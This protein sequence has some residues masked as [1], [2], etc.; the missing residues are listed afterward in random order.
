MFSFV[1]VEH[2]QRRA[3]GK[4]AGDLPVH[5]EVSGSFLWCR[6]GAVDM[7]AETWSGANSP[8]G[9]WAFGLDWRGPRWGAAKMHLNCPDSRCQGPDCGWWQR[10]YRGEGVSQR[11]PE[12]SQPTNHA[13]RDEERIV[14]YWGFIARCCV[15]GSALNRNWSSGIGG[16][17]SG[18]KEN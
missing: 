15:W 7:L 9:D 1:V 13:S 10:D 3:I 16:E 2:T 12:P 18:R 11:I 6:R 4:V 5:E 17:V 8:L 14:W